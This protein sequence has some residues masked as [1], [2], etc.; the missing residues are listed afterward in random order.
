MFV[1][2]KRSSDPQAGFPFRKGR[3][4]PEA[5]RIPSGLARLL[6]VAFCGTDSV[7]RVAFGQHLRPFRLRES[8]LRRRDRQRAKSLSL[9]VECRPVARRTVLRRTCGALE[10]VAAT[11]AAQIAL[12]GRRNCALPFPQCLHDSGRFPRIHGDSSGRPPR[13]RTRAIPAL[14]DQKLRA[15][16]QLGSMADFEFSSQQHQ[17]VPP[18]LNRRCRRHQTLERVEVVKTRGCS[19]SRAKAGPRTAGS[20][21]RPIPPPSS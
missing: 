13:R 3:A 21:A 15:I 7:R 18:R 6:R 12:S 2:P 11:P 5:S 20:R 19:R 14:Y 17:H 9:L 1:F 16:N 10:Q 4:A 8:R